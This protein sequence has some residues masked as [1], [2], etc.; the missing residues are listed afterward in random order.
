[1][2][3]YAAGKPAIWPWSQ[4]DRRAP[5]DIFAPGLLYPKN[6]RLR[7][8]QNCERSAT[9]LARS[10]SNT[11][12]AVPPGLAKGCSDIHLR[13]VRRGADEAAKVGDQGTNHIRP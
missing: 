8:I 12:L 6:G 7:S 9:T 2:Q 5:S 10:L 3:K 11:S 1:M 4:K 13:R